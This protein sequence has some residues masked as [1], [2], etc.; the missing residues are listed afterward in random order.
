MNEYKIKERKPIDWDSFPYGYNLT[1]QAKDKGSPQKFSAVK[2]V[3]IASPKKES[4]PLM[5]EK[6]AYDTVISE[7]SPP[8]VVVAVVKLVPEPHSVEYRISPSEDAEYFKINPNTANVKLNLEDGFLDFYSVNRQAP[9]F[10]KSFPT[11]VKVSED[12]PVGATILRIK[13][14]DADS[15]FNGRVL[16]TIS[17][18]NVD[19]CFNIDMEMGILSV[20]MP[21]DREKTELYLLNITIY[22]LGNPQKSAWR[23]LTV[24]VED[25]ND[26]KPVFLQDSYSVNILESTSLGTEII[27]VEARDKDLGA[28]GEV[29]YSVLTD[30]HQFAINSSTGV[31]YVADQLDREAK[32]N[33]TLKI[34]ARDRA[35]SGHQQ[36][37][38]VPLK[39]FLDDVNDCSPAFIPS[40]YNVKYTFQHLCVTPLRGQ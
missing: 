7:F 12:L 37:S 28:N 38:V 27:Q 29:T 11:D 10:D 40:S 21:L 5:F 15:G 8:G 33:Y 14:Y 3:H 13:A 30:T 32:A 36:F 26:N 39:V 9:H 34:E 4:I 19:S 2:L 20:L 31:V 17:D 6:E 16:Y 22:D 24:T 23:L 18:G 1:L 25:A 35:E